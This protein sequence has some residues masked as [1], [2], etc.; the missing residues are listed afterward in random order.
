MLDSRDL[1]ALKA[2]LLTLKTCFIVE[3]DDYS[4]YTPD[5][6][7]KSVGFRLLASASVEHYVEDRCLAVARTGTLRYKKSQPSATGRALTIWYLAKKLKRSIPLRDSEVLS[8]VDLIDDALQS[9]TNTVKGSHGIDASDLRNLVLPLGVPDSSVPEALY[10]QLKSWA[11]SRNPASH[12]RLP[13]PQSE[14]VAEWKQVESLVKLLTSV[15]HA[16][17]SAVTT[18]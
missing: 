11:D 7:L 1:V 2:N 18:F 12:R 14:P 17:E 3:R 9:Y 13:K 15:D 5:D 4:A 10:D 16:L 8:H 6:Q